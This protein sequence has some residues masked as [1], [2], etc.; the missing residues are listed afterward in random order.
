[1]GGYGAFVWSAFGFTLLAMGGLFWQSW[2]D[3]DRQ[4]ADLLR[5]RAEVRPERQRRPRPLT[6]R[7]EPEPDPGAAGETA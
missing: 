1:M 2:R 7:R 3:A 5:L 4:E 6:A